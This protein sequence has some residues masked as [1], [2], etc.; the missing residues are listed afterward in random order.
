MRPK[1]AQD[2][3]R[4]YNPVIE[5]PK[6][7]ALV[8]EQDELDRHA[9][10]CVIASIIVGFDRRRFALTSL[11]LQ[12]FDAIPGCQKPCCRAFLIAF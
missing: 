7:M 12:P 9:A 6:A 4:R 5:F 3:I 1:P 11:E 2:G 8:I 10:F